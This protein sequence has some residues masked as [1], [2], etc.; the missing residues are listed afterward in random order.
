M[1]RSN[2]KAEDV[3]NE[4]SQL[5][6]KLSYRVTYCRHLAETIEDATGDLEC[7]L[8]N[9]KIMAIG[10]ASRILLSEADETAKQTLELLGELWAICASDKCDA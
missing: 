10:G 6:A 9:D 1:R 5:L 8:D 2:R 3:Y 4:A 7:H